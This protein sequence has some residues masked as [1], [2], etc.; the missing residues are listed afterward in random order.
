MRICLVRS[1]DL[2]GSSALMMAEELSLH[3][4]V[5]L[6]CRYPTSSNIH[7]VGRTSR[8]HS[9]MAMISASQ[10][11]IAAVAISLTLRGGDEAVRTA[12]C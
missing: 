8:A 6:R 1:D 2:S 9:D 4:T 12:V 3:S 10:D 11:D 7:L 5:G